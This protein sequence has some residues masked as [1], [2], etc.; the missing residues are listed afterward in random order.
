[1]NLAQ[2]TAKLRSLDLPRGDYTVFGSGPLLVRGIIAE[3]SDLDVIA[4]GSAWGLAVT[5]G[6]ELYLA[7]HGITVASFF[8]GLVTIG[9]SWAIGD[10]DIDD[11]IDTSEDFDGLPYVRLEHVVAYKR[12]AA[13]PKDIEHLGRLQLWLDSIGDAGH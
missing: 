3:V 4:R 8:A 7:E 5:T 2:A 6:T 13:R 9:T 12:L 10:V 1:M 11:A